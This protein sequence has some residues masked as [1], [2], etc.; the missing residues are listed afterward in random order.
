[1]TWSAFQTYW[2]SYNWYYTTY[3]PTTTCHDISFSHRFQSIGHMEMVSSSCPSQSVPPCRYI[4]IYSLLLHWDLCFCVPLCEYF[5]TAIIEELGSPLSMVDYSWLISSRLF[6]ICTPW[7]FFLLWRVLQDGKLFSKF[8]I[9]I[10]LLYRL[11][12]GVK[13][14]IRCFSFEK[15]Y[16]IWSFVHIKAVLLIMLFIELDDVKF[17]NTLKLAS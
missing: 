6:N 9:K 11:A 3:H 12:K 4:S 1:M 14:N 15:N 13:I 5:M 7:M 16:K 2:I 10:T 8:W 17:C